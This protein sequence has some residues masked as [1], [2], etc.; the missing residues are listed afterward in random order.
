MYC[1]AFSEHLSHTLNQTIN[2]TSAAS[3]AGGDIN[4]SYQLETNIGRLFIKLNR[5]SLLPMM[6]SEQLSLNHIRA[7]STISCPKPLASGIFANQSWLL[8]EFMPIQPY[9]SDFDKG[10]AL[11]KLHK[12]IEPENRFGWQQDNFI[13]FSPQT[14]I[15]SSNWLDFYANQRLLPQLKMANRNGASRQLNS[16]GKQ[17]IQKLPLWFTHYQPQA[18]LLHGDLWAGNSGFLN[19]G[20]PIIFD[21][22]SYYG[23]RETDIAMTEL[24]GGYTTD[25]YQGYQS[26]YPLNDGYSSRKKLYNLYHSLNHFNRFGGSYASQAEGMIEQLLASKSA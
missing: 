7:T 4:Q 18:S 5:A 13:G 9:G 15:W 24:F 2:I 8:L 14:N 17:L 3:V 25:F 22:A 11:A 6:Q 16:L 26:V 21:P 23:D 19:N 10:C 20:T 12:Q 1:T